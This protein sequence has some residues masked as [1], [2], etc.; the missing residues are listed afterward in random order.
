[1]IKKNYKELIDRFPEIFSHAEGSQEP[2]ALFG[3]ECDTGWYNIIEGAC[4]VLYR[5]CR[6]CKQE[7]DFLEK[8]LKNIDAYV[9][10]QKSYRP[11]KNISD[12]EIK[13]KLNTDYK[14]AL[15]AL[16]KTKQALPKV[17]QIKEKFGTLRFYID[18]G[19]ETS[20]AITSYAEH[21]SETTC[22]KCGNVG[23]TYTI[24]WHK[25]LCK[26]H[27]IQNYGEETIKQFIKE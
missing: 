22:E 27:A 11:D 25:T 24:G 7:V 1:M 10:R 23:R 9:A 5:S 4:S 17:V 14:N 13:D 12:D 20:F 19:N 8:N 3:F 18:N 26:E 21:M 15:E 6:S 2:F 16:E